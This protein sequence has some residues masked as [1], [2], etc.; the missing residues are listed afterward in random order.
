VQRI[1]DFERSQL[2]E[3]ATQLAQPELSLEARLEIAAQ[4]SDLLTGREAI[5]LNENG[6]KQAGVQDGQRAPSPVFLGRLDF[7]PILCFW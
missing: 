5:P 4:M 3:L 2:M 6:R 1:N 7:I